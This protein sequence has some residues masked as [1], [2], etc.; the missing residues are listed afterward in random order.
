[1][2]VIQFR[3][4]GLSLIAILLVGCA[5]RTP[6][7]IDPA[8]SIPLEQLQHWQLNAR[9]AITTPEDNATASLKWLKQKSE[10]DFLVSGPLGVTVAHLVQDDGMAT[11]SI[12]DEQ[13]RQH[14]D[15]QILLYQTLGWDFPIDAL[16][17]WVKG[18]PSGKPGEEISYNEKGQI[19]TIQLAEWRINLSKYRRYQGY[20]LPKML[21]AV[22]PRMSIKVVAKRWQFYK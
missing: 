7:L 5:G 19:E 12:P 8:K 20:L 14:Q 4:I 11:L 10:F 15:A 13:K 3:L 6:T 17:F 22:H 18:I 16:T 2:K 21:K 1:M 9:I